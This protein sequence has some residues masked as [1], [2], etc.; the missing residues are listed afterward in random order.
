L[1]LPAG[2]LPPGKLRPAPG[3]ADPLLLK[4]RPSFILTAPLPYFRDRLPPPGVGPEWVQMLGR[5]A[6]ADWVRQDDNRVT[7]VLATGPYGGGFGRAPLRLRLPALLA[8][9][10]VSQPEA[11]YPAVSGELDRL[12]ARHRWG[13]IQDPAPIRAGAHAVW[14]IEPTGS[15]LL[16]NLGPADRPAYAVA[17]GRLI[18][19]S[20][21][22]SLAAALARPAEAADTAP[23]APWRETLTASNVAAMAWLDLQAGGNAL[24]LVL[25]AWALFGRGPNAPPIPAAVTRAGA[26]L[27]RL[28]PLQSGAVWLES[29]NGNPLLRL[30]IGPPDAR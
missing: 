24:Q 26:L 1:R 10:S 12:N 3:E 21:A 18:A 5:I 11:V 13:V 25:S 29:E 27:D 23:W 2:L 20:Q 6:Q 22:G 8:S 28:R 30:Q 19:A 14:T 4:A 17:D 9:L 15:A 16:S 7:L